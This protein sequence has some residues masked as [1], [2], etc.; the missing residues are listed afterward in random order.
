MMEGGDS[1]EDLWRGR[2]R[3]AGPLISFVGHPF[4][5][6]RDC[7]C[8]C[9]VVFTHARLSSFLRGLLH[10]LSGRG[11]W[12]RLVV[13]L[14]I[15]QGS[16]CLWALVVP[17]W[18]RCRLW[19][20]GRPWGVIVTGVRCCCPWVGHRCPQV[21]HCLLWVGLVPCC[22]LSIMVN[23]H[24][25]GGCGVGVRM[26]WGF[27]WV[28]GFRMGVGVHIGVVGGRSLLS[29]D[30][31]LLWWVGGRCAWGCQRRPSALWAGVCGVVEK[32][33]VNV[34]HPDGCAMSAA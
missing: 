28:V 12:F 30:G 23:I 10:L 6:V 3:C 15:C 1:G 25:G 4:S 29:V 17:G 22:G 13:H 21:G 34:A 33:I 18:A 20:E 5:F 26:V 24:M 2:V 7:F 11:R 8:S 14:V 31:A 19:V 16:L 27:T 32:A 9:A